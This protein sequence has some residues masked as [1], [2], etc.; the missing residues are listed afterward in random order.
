MFV[1]K[2]GS[3]VSKIGITNPMYQ[4]SISEQC[5]NAITFSI[6]SLFEY[7]GEKRWKNMATRNSTYEV[8]IKTYQHVQNLDM[9]W[10]NE[11]FTGNILNILNSE[12][13]IKL[14][15]FLVL[16]D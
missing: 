12:I 11:K 10:F 9:S 5:K 6:E 7:I 16:E 15:C 13:K 1:Y 3:F 4:I 8:R 2:T 14:I